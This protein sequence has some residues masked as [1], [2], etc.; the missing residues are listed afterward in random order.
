MRCCWPL[1]ARAAVLALLGCP[2]DPVAGK[3]IHELVGRVDVVSDPVDVDLVLGAASVAG[4]VHVVGEE[5]GVGARQRVDPADGTVFALEP[6]TS[7]SQLS[8]PGVGDPGGSV[9]GVA[10]D[11]AGNALYVGGSANA[12]IGDAFSPTFWQDPSS[13]AFVAD[14]FAAGT[15][16]DIAS[17]GVFVGFESQAVVGTLSQGVRA[18]DG[19]GPSDTAIGISESGRMAVGSKVWMIDPVTLD[20]TVID[21]SAWQQPVDASFLADFR[22]VIDAPG[23]DAV[24]FREYIDAAVKPHVGAWRVSDGALLGST[25]PGTVFADGAFVEETLV[26][27]VNGESGGELHTLVDPDQLLLGDLLGQSVSIAFDSFFTG[28]FGLV[29]AGGTNAAT[30]VTFAPPT[31]GDMDCDGDV[32]FDDIDELVVGLT[33]PN[34]YESIYGVP[35]QLKGDTDGDGDLDF[36][37]IGGFV[38]ILRTPSTSVRVP[39]P[40][41]IGLAILAALLLASVLGV[42]CTDFLLFREA[43]QNDVRVW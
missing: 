35:P 2:A 21:T 33:N 18:L 5:S 41:A 14:P 15:L 26:V 1:I 37:D 22:G 8:D 27:G 39:E 30:V 43:E 4:V 3:T 17:T 24:V 42:R 29:T 28:S 23:D 36:D 34:Q 40:P 12:S 32:D 11:G 25:G 6:F 16:E 13:P 7:H 19:T 9:T 20:S 31:T 10:A 38:A